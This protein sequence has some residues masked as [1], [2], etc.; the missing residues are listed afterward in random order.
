MNFEVSTSD[1][2]LIVTLKRHRGQ[3]IVNWDW[4]G[5]LQYDLTILDLCELTVVADKKRSRIVLCTQKSFLILTHSGKK[6][7]I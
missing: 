2:A 1:V 5:G 6:F 4:S 7:G 3:P